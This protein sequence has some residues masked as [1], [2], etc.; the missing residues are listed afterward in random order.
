MNL[1]AEIEIKGSSNK[2]VANPSFEEIK[3]IVNSLDKTQYAVLI[4]SLDVEWEVLSIVKQDN[5]FLCFYYS[6]E[7][8]YL[9]NK[10]IN[11]DDEWEVDMPDTTVRPAKYFNKLN[12]VLVA[13]K[14]YMETGKLDS[15][16]TW[17]VW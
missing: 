12:D 8:C 17:E 10:E 9:V 13:T 14:T 4:K 5:Y 11:I 7:E 2:V 1:E 3:R 16:L 15:T 6:N